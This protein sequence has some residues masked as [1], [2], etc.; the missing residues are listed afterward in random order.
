MGSLNEIATKNP[1]LLEPY[2]NALAQGGDGVTMF[3]TTFAQDGLLLYVSKNSCVEKTIQLMNVLRSNVDLL[4][5]RRLLIVLE[6]GAQASMLVCDHA[7]EKIKSL[8]VQ[9][10]EVFIGRNARLDLC[11]LEETHGENVR[12]AQLFVKQEAGSSFNHTTITLTNGLTRNSAHVSL[13]G[14]GAEVNMYGLAISDKKQHVE[15]HTLVDHVVG[16]CNS[17]ELYKYVCSNIDFDYISQDTP[18]YSMNLRIVRFKI[19]ENSY[20]N[21]ITNL[22]EDEFPAAEIK[23]LYHL[24]WN[25]ELTFRDLKQTIATEQFHCKNRDY[26][27]MEIYARMVL[28]NFCSIITAQTVVKKKNTKYVYQINYSMAIKLCHEFLSEYNGSSIDVISLTGNFL[29]PV[30]PERKYERRKRLQP[31]ARFAYRFI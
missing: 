15:N 13:E 20:E 11:E 8:S 22:P 9:V 14:E 31:P 27:G 26:I 16:R 2:Y 21:I 24:R 12:L 29:L 7:V 17:N 3:N 5:N 1:S 18:E 30:K 19:S 6:D 4:I 23:K 10:A 25:I 28:Y